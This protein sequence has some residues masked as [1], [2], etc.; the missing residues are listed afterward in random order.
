MRVEGLEVAA[1]PVDDDYSTLVRLANHASK[2]L[3]EF[4]AMD[5]GLYRTRELLSELEHVIAEFRSLQP[6]PTLDK[7]PALHIVQKCLICKLEIEAD[8]E[9]FETPEAVYHADCYERKSGLPKQK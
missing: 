5:P 8:Q 3:R 1:K 7:E 4:I 2:L 6:P 9:S